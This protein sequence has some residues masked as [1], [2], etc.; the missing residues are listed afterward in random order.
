[1]TSLAKLITL[2]P[3]PAQPT[4]AKGDWAAVEADLG[5]S[6]PEDYKS[7]VSLYGSGSISRI[8]VVGNP[9]LRAISARRYWENWVDIY[10]DKASYG[11]EIPYDLYPNC[12]GLLPCGSYLDSDI[13]NWL[14]DKDLNQWR[15]LYYGRGQ[16]FFDLGSTSLTEFLVQ[17]LTGT[18]P[19]PRDVL[20][21]PFPVQPP[22]FI[23]LAMP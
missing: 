3:P 9:F 15:L 1:M 2:V 13:I 19:L 14:T 12:P 16:G 5:F 11:I 17:V 7:F 4:A 18:A 20:S 6:L 21:S 22:R 10:R 8:I 23:P